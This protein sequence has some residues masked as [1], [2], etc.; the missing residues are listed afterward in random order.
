MEPNSRRKM[1]EK[2][3]E[4]AAFALLL[5]ELMAEE[6]A[7][8]LRE[9]ETVPSADIPPETDA[10]CRKTIRRADAGVRRRQA[11]HFMGKAVSRVAV[12]FFIA[13]MA[14]TVPFCTVS[15]FRTSSLNLIYDTFDKGTTISAD[16]ASGKQ[17]IA[18]KSPSWFP[19]GK[20]KTVFLDNEENLYV[21]RFKD[22]DANIIFY[23]EM[24]TEGSTVSIDSEDSIQTDVLVN[25][26]SALMAVK[27]NQ[28]ILVWLDSADSTI[29]TL[30]LHGS[31][32]LFTPD[33]A[34]RIAESIE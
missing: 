18:V 22:S 6:G 15:A 11:L 33:I 25:G 17:E 27:E 28:I 23:S 24:P 2:Q 32:E 5:D 10:R 16:D 1:L 19:S 9:A 26:H 20:W 34:I 30:E 13:A 7:A 12:V 29:C 21:I 3:Y 31:R 8:L 14:V 4:Q